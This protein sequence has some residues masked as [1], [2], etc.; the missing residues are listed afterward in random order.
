MKKENLF[1]LLT[2]A[3]AAA[4]IMIFMLVKENGRA[5]NK[6]AVSMEQYDSVDIADLA[7]EDTLVDES[8]AD[9]E[10]IGTGKSL[11]DIRFADFDEKDWVDNDYI[12]ELR[13]YIDDLKSGKVED[14]HSLKDKVQGKFIVGTSGPCLVGGLLVRIV[15][16]DRP[17]NIFTSAIYSFVNEDTETVTGYE[18]RSFYLDEEESGITKEQLLKLMDEHSELKLW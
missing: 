4:I 14:E 13:K 17:E 2:V 16:I 18:V 12:R 15:F 9:N 1:L 3:S 10:D 7:V 8:F 5:M 11:N 6:E